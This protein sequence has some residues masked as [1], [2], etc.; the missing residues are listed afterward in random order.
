VDKFFAK[1]Q[2]SASASPTEAVT[3]RGPTDYSY[4]MP[5]GEVIGVD[6]FY[7]N[8]H[9][10][11]NHINPFQMQFTPVLDA[12]GFFQAGDWH[13]TLLI[14]DKRWGNHNKDTGPLDKQALR[15]KSYM[16]VLMQTDN[17]NGT[18][19]VHCHIL[20]HEDVGMMLMS[21]IVGPRGRVFGA[22]E[23]V[24]PTCYRGATVRPALIERPGSCPSSYPLEDDLYLQRVRESFLR[25]DAVTVLNMP[26][27]SP[28]EDSGNR[29]TWYGVAVGFISAFALAVSLVVVLVVIAVRRRR[30]QTKQHGSATTTLPVA[31]SRSEA[32]D[33][34]YTSV[35][36]VQPHEVEVVPTTSAG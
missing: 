22:A 9:P 19:V 14:P 16:R 27:A 32:P 26:P 8:W 10:F 33:P 29:G 17:F 36:S 35:V 7:V 31:P 28:P 3:F 23:R 20:Q 4:V 15:G 11:H 30:F 34:A 25:G 21:Q 18:Q 12:G 24:D 13:D 6:L 2:L 5:V 1:M